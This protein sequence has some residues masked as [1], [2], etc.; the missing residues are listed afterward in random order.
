MGYFMDYPRVR[1][2]IDYSGIDKRSFQAF[3]FDEL[4]RVGAQKLRVSL[5]GLFESGKDNVV[6][7]SGGLD[8]RLILSALLECTEPGNIHT[9]TYGIPGTYDYEIGRLVAQKAG[10][11]HTSIPMNAMSWH[12]DELVEVAKREDCQAVLFYSQPLRQIERMFGGCVFWS[13]YV[14]DAVAGSHLHDPPSRSLDDAKRVYLRNR[15]F[16]RSVKLS[17]A[18]DEE[19]LPLIAGGS[20]PPETLTW[21]EQVL[22]DEG[23]AKFT[24]AHAIWKDFEYQTPLINSPWMDFMFSVPNQHRLGQKLMI[25]IGRAAFPKLFNL[26]SK[27]RIGHTFD[28]PDIVVKTTFWLNRVRKVAHQFLP[29]VNYPPIQ[30]DDFNEAIRNNPSLRKVVH[31]SIEDLRKRGTCDWVN[32]ERIWRRHDR[33]LGNH[34]D[35]LIALA[36]LELILKARSERSNQILTVC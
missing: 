32:P 22:F 12:E 2:G 8:S 36:S 24:V 18:E 35:A 16:V 26:P 28:T 10:T 21:D 34:G 30:Y 4:V 33:R 20:L 5:D 13:G 23:V 19:L 17:R 27:N 14:G 11:R 6:P 25:E 7:L 9:Y 15:T 3:P 1:K 31:D 29:S